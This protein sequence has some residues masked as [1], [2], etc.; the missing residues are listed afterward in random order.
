MTIVLSLNNSVFCIDT[1]K[2][3]RPRSKLLLAVQQTFKMS[4]SDGMVDV[5]HTQFQTLINQNETTTTELII[6]NKK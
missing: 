6:T 2:K 5:P 1:L 3:V 4:V